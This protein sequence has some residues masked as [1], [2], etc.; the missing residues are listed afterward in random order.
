MQIESLFLDEPNTST[1]SMCAC[2]VKFHEHFC[3]VTKMKLI[4]SLS[5]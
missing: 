5:N 3:D 2:Y 4:A 1:D